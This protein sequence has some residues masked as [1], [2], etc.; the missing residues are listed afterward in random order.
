MPDWMLALYDPA[1]VVGR[2]LFSLVFITNGLAHLT[3]TNG[4]S[5]YAASKGVPAAKAMTI[6]TGLMMLTGGVFVALG[7]HRFIGA[8]LIALFVIPTAFIMHPY[9]KATD[10][11]ARAGEQAHFYKDLALG[12]AAL[13]IAYY[14]GGDWPFAL[15]TP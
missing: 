1:H 10:P 2:F 15:G 11:G 7:W 12:G 5:G 6:I 8:G 9:W 4:L 3:K 13:V 14:A